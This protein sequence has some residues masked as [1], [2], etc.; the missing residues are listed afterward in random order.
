MI[1]RLGTDHLPE[2]DRCVGCGRPYSP[3][4]W[5]QKF[6]EQACRDRHYSRAAKDSTTPDGEC[7]GCGRSVPPGYSVCPRSPRCASRVRWLVSNIAKSDNFRRDLTVSFASRLRAWER[8]K[9]KARATGAPIPERPV[10]YDAVATS[11][12]D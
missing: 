5:R 10:N 3:R 4:A 1:E 11:E 12:E 2:I 9:Q 7:A 8:A 6:C